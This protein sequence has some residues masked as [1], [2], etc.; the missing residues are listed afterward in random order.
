MVADASLFERFH[1]DGMELDL[2]R[3]EVRDSNPC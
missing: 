2:K 1:N 3:C